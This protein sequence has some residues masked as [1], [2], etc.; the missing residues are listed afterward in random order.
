MSITPPR[1]SAPLTFSSRFVWWLLTAISSRTWLRRRSIHGASGQFRN[2]RGHVRIHR[3]AL[4]SGRSPPGVQRE[5]L[6]EW[7]WLLTGYL[8]VELCEAL[9]RFIA[10][11]DQEVVAKVGKVQLDRSDRGVQPVDE[12]GRPRARPEDV[13]VLEIAVN[14]TPLVLGPGTANHLDQALPAGPIT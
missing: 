3:L 7:V 11:V 12:P 5:R 8:P 14:E 13:V 10:K 9:R 4:R 1:A 6:P 2:Q